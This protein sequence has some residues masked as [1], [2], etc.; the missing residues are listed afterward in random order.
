MARGSIQPDLFD[1]ALLEWVSKF[2]AK[3]SLYW[4]E[5]SFWPLLIDNLYTGGTEVPASWLPAG[6]DARIFQTPQLLVSYRF[7][8]YVFF[9]LKWDIH[10]L[11]FA[12]IAVQDAV[13]ELECHFSTDNPKKIH[14]FLLLPNA[15]QS[16]RLVFFDR[17]DLPQESFNDD[18]KWVVKREV[19]WHLFILELFKDPLC[20]I[21]SQ[22]EIR[23]LWLLM[24]SVD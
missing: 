5:T 3:A 21:V 8:I 15:D 9:F 4:L 14:I 2:L 24:L 16:A 7:N 10:A 23:H 6:A 18:W 17:G 11:S 22:I 1:N 12:I 19:E 13:V 20:W